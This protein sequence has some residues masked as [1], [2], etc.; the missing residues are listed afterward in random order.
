MPKC[1][2]CHEGNFTV[3]HIFMLCDNFD[4]TREYL[5]ND[6]QE[7]DDD[8]VIN[9]TLIRY[10]HNKRGDSNLVYSKNIQKVFE[11]IY[12]IWKVYNDKLYKRT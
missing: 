12:H 10:G 7:I 5:F 2:L 6:L 8:I 9:E 11:Y 3:K 4:G 1:I